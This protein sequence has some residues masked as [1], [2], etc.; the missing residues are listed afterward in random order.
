MRSTTLK[1][2]ALMV[3]SLLSSVGHSARIE[4]GKEL[5]PLRIA[6]LGEC[7]VKGNETAFE[8]WQSSQL[9]G[10][11]QVVEYLAARAGIDRIQQP[12]YAAIKAAELPADRLTLTKVV[13]SDDALFGTAGFV[14]PEVRKGKQQR[15]GETLVVDA[16][17]VGREQWDLR[18]KSSAIAILDAAGT[19]RFFKE[20]AL[21]GEEIERAVALLNQLLK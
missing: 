21:T 10:S 16:K 2:T 19:V 11:V 13:N 20:G 12:L 17:G 4:T 9:L 3:A 8:P 18:R 1:L 6:D 7:V 14:A 15:P 5:P